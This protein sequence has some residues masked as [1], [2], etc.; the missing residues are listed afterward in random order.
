MK[1]ATETL[2]DAA[3]AVLGS[4]VTLAILLAADT[5]DAL[6]KGEFDDED[7]FDNVDR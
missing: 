7:D 4:D 1:I 5:L 6:W 3:L 2:T